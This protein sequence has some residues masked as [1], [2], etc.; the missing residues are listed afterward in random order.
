MNIQ[1]KIK[2]FR[3]EKRLTQAL[4]AEKAGL[5]QGDLS[6]I[7]QGTSDVRLSTLEHIAKAIGLEIMLV[8]QELVHHVA[9]LIPG[10]K[11]NHGKLMTTLERYGV[12]DD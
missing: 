8:P 5:H 1:Q 11:S 4:V 2:Q 6:R 12:P 10:G 7:E 9:P 3:K